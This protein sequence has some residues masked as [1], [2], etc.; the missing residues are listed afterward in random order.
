MGIPTVF[1]GYLHKTR[2]LLES[3]GL[4]RWVIDLKDQNAALFRSKL[5][6]AWT[7]RNQL[8]TTLISMMPGILKMTQQIPELIREDYEKYLSQQ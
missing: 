8:S 4:D 7:E 1:I 5:E 6:E 3:L 2:G